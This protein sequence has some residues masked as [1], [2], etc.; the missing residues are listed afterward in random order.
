MKLFNNSKGV[1]VG[2]VIFIL[3]FL[4]MA[5]R[6][7]KADSELTFVGGSAVVKGYAPAIGL[8][9]RWPEAGPGTTDWEAGFLLSGESEYKGTQ[10]NTVSLYGMLVPN[11]KGFETG[12]GF[13]YHNNAWAYSCQE[14]FALMAGYRTKRLMVRWMHFSSAGSCKP[15]PGRD[16]VLV[17]WRF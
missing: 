13:A 17:G 16:F 12:L 7:A 2:I 4:A 10:P 14:T 8:D 15:N 5:W 3:V 11:Y 6:D 1:V 9:V